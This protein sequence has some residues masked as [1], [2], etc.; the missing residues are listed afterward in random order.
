MRRILKM[1]AAGMALQRMPL[2]AWYMLVT[3]LMIVFGFP[4]LILGSIL[5]ELER[6]FG[7]PFFDAAR[8][9][10][11]LLWQHLF[12]LFGHPEVYIIFL[13]AAGDG[14]DDRAGDRARPLVGYTWVVL[15]VIATGFIS[16]GLWVHHMFTVGI[17]L[18]RAGLLLRGEHAGRDSDGDPV[19]R[20]D[21]DAV[22]GRGR[23]EGALLYI[24][25]FL[26]IF[27]LGGL[28]G[29][30]VALV[31]FDWQAHDTHFVVAHMHY[32]LVGGMVFPLMARPV[33]LAAAHVGKACRRSGSDG[34]ALLA[35]LHRLQRHFPVDALHRLIGMPRRVYTYRPE[36]RLGPA[37]PGLVGRRLRHVGR[38]RAVPDRRLAMTGFGRP[39]EPQSLEGGH[40]RMGHRH[41]AAPPTTSPACPMS[42]AGTPLGRTGPGR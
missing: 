28:T 7:W 17:P 41:A 5:L 3:A 24:L 27:V 35:D 11:P 39:T 20:L 12:W 14:V 4:P 33:L 8:G 23:C 30:M 34:R 29:V 15:A 32:V 31:P 21:R 38:L 42:T 10:D 26:V 19:V 40:A 6:A 1:R 16:F 18:L 25:G 36:S 22:E 9:G 37:Q 2:F 13:P